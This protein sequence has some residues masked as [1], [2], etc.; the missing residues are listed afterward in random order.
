[1]LLLDTNVISE[2]RKA[3]PHGAVVAWLSAQEMRGLFIS[4][5]TLGEMQY[6]A[7]VTRAQD[8][9]KAGEIDEWIDAVAANWNIV[10]LGH[11]ICR[12]WAKLMQGRSPDLSEDAMIA[13]MALEHG[14]TVATRN[15]RDFRPFGVPVVNPFA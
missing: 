8:P 6:G 7:E 14:L 11:A 13:A 9:A 10:P 12:R 4:A 3:R 15:V 2:L 1:M 5:I